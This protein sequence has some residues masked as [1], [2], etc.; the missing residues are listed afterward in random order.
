MR[1]ILDASRPTAK[2][3]NKRAV[4]AS[5][6][7]LK[8]TIADLFSSLEKIEPEPDA[9]THYDTSPCQVACDQNELLVQVVRRDNG[10]AYTGWWVK[11]SAEKLEAI[12]WQTNAEKQVAETA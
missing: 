2:S 1:A 7:G 4:K 8:S 3:S 5:G 10:S 6:D 9:V 11:L 12:T